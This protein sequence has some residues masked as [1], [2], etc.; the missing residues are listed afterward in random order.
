MEGQGCP[1]GRP[2][3]R[4]IITQDVR[5]GDHS[6]LDDALVNRLHR[7]AGADR[8]DVSVAR[9]AAALD[10]SVSRMFETTPSARELE[11]Y[12]ASLHLEDLASG[13]RRRTKR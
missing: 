9:F 6:P 11:R 3:L 8:W 2:S 10:A 13:T 12:L 5:P 7:R 4:S 1:C